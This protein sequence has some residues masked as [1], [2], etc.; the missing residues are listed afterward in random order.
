LLSSYLHWNIHRFLR[1]SWATFAQFSDSELLAFRNTESFCCRA[2]VIKQA[3][4]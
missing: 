2:I 4:L 1:L 3:V